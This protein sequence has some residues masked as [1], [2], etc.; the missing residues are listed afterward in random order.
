MNDNLHKRTCLVLDS[1]SDSPGGPASYTTHLEPVEE[2][3]QDDAISDTKS[4]N[5]DLYVPTSASMLSSGLSWVHIL[6]YTA[7]LQRMCSLDSFGVGKELPGN[8]SPAGFD[9]SENGANHDVVRSPLLTT[10]AML[11][12]HSMLEFLHSNLPVFAEKCLAAEMPTNLLLTTNP[13][14]TEL[15]IS[16]KSYTENV[17]IAQNASTEPVV[18]SALPS[19]GNDRSAT[20]ATDNELCMQWYQPAFQVSS[21]ISNKVFL[22]F[23]IGEAPVKNVSPSKTM[24]ST[25]GQPP[26]LGKLTLSLGDLHDLHGMLAELRQKGDIS[27]S[28]KVSFSNIVQSQSWTEGSWCVFC[29]VLLRSCTKLL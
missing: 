7:I 17:Y 12:L 22:L 20:V 6:G 10:T 28:E 25:T 18:L 23:A 9:D 16:A 19:E 15:H 4:E 5:L 14:P 27:L 8:K 11:R 1:L 29:A 26:V 13:P 2:V 3:T 21:E 24:T